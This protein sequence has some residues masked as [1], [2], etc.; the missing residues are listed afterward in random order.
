MAKINIT[1]FN[2]KGDK[3]VPYS[4]YKDNSFIF[5][6]KELNN[7]KEAYNLLRTNFTLSQSLEI[8]MPTVIQRRKSELNKYKRFKLDNIIL[9]IDKVKSKLDVNSII[10]FFKKE[11]LSVI[12]GKSKSYDDIN[13]FN[14][15]GII[16]VNITNNEDIIRGILNYI[17]NNIKE[18][19]K[20]DKSILSMS[21]YQAATNK[22]VMF[23][24]EYGKIL[25]NNDIEIEEKEN[26]KIFDLDI[27]YDNIII[28]KCLNIFS[29]LGFYSLNSTIEKNGCIRFANRA[30]VKSVG[31]YFWFPNNPIIMHHY[32]K[33]RTISIFNQLKDTVEGKEWLKL[34]NKLEQKQLL[35]NDKNKSNKN[36]KEIIIV[37]E[38]YLNFDKKNKIKMINDFLDEEKSIL[39]ISSAMGSAKSSGIEKTIEIA[40]KK[41]K[42]VI[43]VSNRISVAKDYANKYDLMI[44]SDEN[45]INY[46]GSIVV[47]YDS[48]WKFDLRNY[49][50][51]I[52]DEFQS[53]VLH[54]RAN[55]TD[56]ANINAV[57]FMI[58]LNQKNVLIA[59]AFM[60]GYEDNFF[61][62]RNMYVIRNDYRDNIKL[63][64]YKYK[65]TFISELFNE[66]EL[67]KEGEHLSASFTSLDMMRVVEDELN[68]RG[69][70][71]MTLSS[72]T[73]IYIKELIY[74]KFK[75]KTHNA[76]KVILFTPTLTVGVSILN[77]IK[78]HFHYDTGMSTD[79]IS[80]LQMIKRSR[81]SK[82]IHFYIES[83]QFYYDTNLNTLNNQAFRDITKFYAN[84][85]KTL[86]IDIDYETGE[87]KLTPLAKYINKI[88][89]FY[90]ILKNNHANAFKI[91]LEYQFKTGYETIDYE[92]L[93]FNL[94]EKIKNIKEKNNEKSLEI[95]NKY[96][97]VIWSDEDLNNIKFK[98]I[99][100]TEKEK[101]ILL[102]NDVAKIFKKGLPNKDILLDITQE[103]I[104]SNFNYVSFIKNF[105]TVNK[106]LHDKEYGK[107]ILSNAISNDISA[108]QNKSYIKFLNKIIS[109]PDDFKLKQ[110]Y[111]KNDLKNSKDKYFE[112]FLKKIGFKWNKGKLRLDKKIIKYSKYI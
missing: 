15:K 79:V 68:N 30:E 97:D 103:E 57:K 52:L 22:A 29:S 111:S 47:Q 10:N 74:K 3:K 86:L 78:H 104:K 102:M 92:D 110:S 59:D 94:K 107:Y 38:R 41:N 91:L 21:S 73:S 89:V 9:D 62:N 39:K 36:I 46:K 56:N 26:K 105:N 51:A 82:K 76:F 75:E 83:R 63:I 112:Q 43:I 27:S 16:K 5:V 33:E 54:H 61:I 23:H 87:L 34:K 1:I 49:D 90:N 98:T 24:N 58:L 50:I 53:L 70:K 95:L 65:T 11:N 55:L 81:F 45:A 96:S 7:L 40:R 13:N 18:Y 100:L 72:E 28:D 2:G 25:N 77:D 69:I 35:N 66:A 93:S 84:K 71:T 64:N 48:L 20:I 101:A 44:Y 14:L 12:I 67:L 17:D 32:N 37:N 106:I 88:E 31:S 19:G 8:K 80:S 42:K 60:T 99:D 109:F 108:L 6:N 4:I 85:N